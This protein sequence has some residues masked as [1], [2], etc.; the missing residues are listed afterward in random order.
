MTAC[1]I[2]SNY[3]TGFKCSQVEERWPK[4]KLPGFQL[5]DQ[6]GSA[7]FLVLWGGVSIGVDNNTCII[8]IHDGV[9]VG[10]G[11]LGQVV[12]GWPFVQYLY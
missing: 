10:C 1:E 3:V 12:G 6:S 8:H 5:G 11:G 4:R 9:G 2:I 7:R